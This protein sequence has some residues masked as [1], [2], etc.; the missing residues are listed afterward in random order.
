MEEFAKQLF[1]DFAEG[2]IG[3]NPGGVPVGNSKEILEGTF[4]EILG[5][6]RGVAPGGMLGET[7]RRICDGTTTGVLD[8]SP[9]RSLKKL[10]V[11]F[12]KECLEVF[13]VVF[14]SHI[15]NK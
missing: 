14:L 7:P 2:T 6:I 12:R 11:K 10:L 3:A 15:L 4:G 9:R 5:G 13:P 1:E 8:R